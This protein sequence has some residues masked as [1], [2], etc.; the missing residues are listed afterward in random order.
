MPETMSVERRNLLNAYGAQLVLTPGPDGMGGE[1]LKK[2]EELLQPHPGSFM[3]S[4]S[5]TYL[6]LIIHRE[7]PPGPKSGKTQTV[8]SDILVAGAERAANNNR[9]FRIH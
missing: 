3:R 4:N 2:A 7:T 1:P 5:K 8:K 6:I 9:L